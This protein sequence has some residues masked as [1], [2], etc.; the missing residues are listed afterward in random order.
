LLPE[1][2][3]YK[4]FGP[5]FFSQAYGMGIEREDMY[6]LSGVIPLLKGGI[7][8]EVVGEHGHMGKNWKTFKFTNIF[9]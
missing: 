3:I 5:P 6:L 1:N 2:Y 8:L 9:V 4:E 7:F